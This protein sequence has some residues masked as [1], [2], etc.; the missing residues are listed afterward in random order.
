[1]YKGFDDAQA[2][3]GTNR[4][5]H[6][7]CGQTW[8]DTFHETSKFFSSSNQLDTLQIVTW[9]DYEEGTEIE[10]GIDGCTFVVASVSGST[11]NW[12][13]QGGPES[14]VDHFTLF[15]STDGQNLAKL[16]DIPAGQHSLG[17]TAFNLS[18]P[19]SLFVKAVGQ[20]SVRNA[21]SSPVVM[22]AGDAAP[23]A[24]LNVS[25]TGDLTVNASTVGSSD[26]DGSIAKT[27]IDFGDGTVVQSATASHTY[28]AAGTFIVTGAVVDKG[29]PW[30]GAA[31]GVE[32]K[33][34]APA[35]SILSPPN[36]ATV[37]FPTPIV[38][39]ANSA[40]PITRMDVL[41]DGAPAHADDRGVVNS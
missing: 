31:T 24:A 26:P 40:N 11:L 37:N 15:A 14:T 8:L 25:L 4:Q 32:A 18:S 12:T 10:S 36:S 19:V 30:G 38:A 1:A 13:V 28:A 22:K 21:M 35:P 29:G 23:H 5:I 9:N 6:H 2:I 41:I 3:F 39:S 20:P 27:T 17:L 16:A 7:Q 33:A 34:V